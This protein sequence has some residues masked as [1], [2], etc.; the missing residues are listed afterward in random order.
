MEFQVKFDINEKIFL[1]NPESSEVGKLMVKKSI[2]LIYD[3]GFEQFTFKK[4]ALEINSTEATIY[5]YFENKHRLLLYILN[6]YWCYMEFLVTFK[7]E[8]VVDKKERLKI[9]VHLL[10]HEFA[11]STNQFDYNK[12]LL[13]QIVIAESSKVY[14]VK[15]VTEINKNEVFK[16]YKDLCGKIAEVISAYNSKYKYPRSLSTTLIETS[17]HQQYFSV[18]LPKLTDV[19]SKNNSEFTNQFIE[20]FLF[21]IL[22]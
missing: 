18:N 7:L 20:D 11:E 10:T 8:N 14:L 22:D 21:K 3:L 2:D 16:P 17:H 15:E 9:I 19:S 12:K 6:W 13:N 4:L 1:R 5:R